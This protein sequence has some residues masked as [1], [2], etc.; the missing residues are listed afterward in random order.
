M[1]KSERRRSHIG[2]RPDIF[3]HR[4]LQALRFEL[5]RTRGPPMPGREFR[6]AI[7]SRRAPCRERGQTFIVERSPKAEHGPDKKGS[8]LSDPCT[9]E[10]ARSCHDRVRPSDPRRPRLRRRS[11]RDRYVADI[12][13]ARHRLSRIATLSP[14][15]SKWAA[16]G[17]EPSERRKWA[18]SLHIARGAEKAL[19][20]IESLAARCYQIKV[21]RPAIVVL[22]L[23]CTTIVFASLTRISTKCA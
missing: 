2:R 10:T 17:G 19:K 4:A 13:F 18:S 14:S 8:L 16:T 15:A 22:L 3:R 7:A 1:T 12:G 9:R 23:L 20:G 5:V 11:G 21:T 6:P